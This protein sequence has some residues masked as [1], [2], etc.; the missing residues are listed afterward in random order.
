MPTP[1]SLPPSAAPA[2]GRLTASVLGAA[3]RRMEAAGPLDDQA[4]LRRAFAAGG[5]REHQITQRNAW[6]GERLGLLQELARWRQLGVLL[7]LAL[8]VLMALAGLAAARSVLA[9]DRS[10]NAVAA[11]V[12]V[13]ALP[14]LALLAWLAVL[15]V[16]GRGIGTADWSFGRMVLTLV[17][18]LLPGHSPHAPQLLQALLEV[19][20]RQ[21]LWPWFSGLASHAIWLLALVLTVIVLMYG[22]S[23]QAYRLS[24]ETTI[25]SAEFFQ[26]FVAT[27][28]W[29][30]QLLGFPVPDAAAIQQVGDAAA[31][32]DL[33]TQ[34][35]WAW[36]LIGCIAVYGLLPRLLLLGLSVWRWRV[37]LARMVV[38][39]MADPYNHRLARRL[40]ALAPQS[41]VID[42][43]GAGAVLVPPWTRLGA[44]GGTAGLAVIGFE[45]PD[46]FSGPVPGL[47]PAFADLLRVDGSAESGL[48]ALQQLAAAPPAAALVVLYGLASPDR[49]TGRFLREV[50]QR[51]AR[52][53]LVLVGPDGSPADADA[54]ARWRDWLQAQELPQF[55]LLPRAADAARWLE[56]A[57]A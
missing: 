28:G 16:A 25:L 39:D 51:V 55:E 40:D 45:L 18:R 5:D 31:H 43:E 12:G 2:P 19:M 10:I 20:Q 8:A 42:P 41:Q 47:P 24:W 37:G 57:H 6:L 48:Q 44:G 9:L 13:L 23:F 11:V 50:A 33:A 14:T 30:P 38:V 7:I 52:C 54:T 49:G 53:A 32:A 36:W 26:W 27:S 1:T 3:L 46:E 22:F 56:S 29:L 15:L 21:R 35:A 34:R 17:A 4:V